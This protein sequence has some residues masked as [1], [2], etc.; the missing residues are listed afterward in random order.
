MNAPRVLI[1]MAAQWHR[2]LIRA[3]LREAGYDALGA[4]DLTEALSY[5]QAE[6][7]RGPVQLIILDQG[8]IGRADDALLAEL[9]RRHSDPT[10]L[11]LESAF[12]PSVQGSWQH[13]LRHPVSIADIVSTAQKL[14]PLPAAHPMD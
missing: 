12:H 5:P 6:H 8:V 2:A 11:V 3:A 10:T 1:V 9:L 14:L 13:V 4:P 7:R